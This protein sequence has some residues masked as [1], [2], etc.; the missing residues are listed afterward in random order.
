M[1]WLLSPT[2]HVHFVADKDEPALKRLGAAYKLTSTNLG[3]MRQ[4]LGWREVGQDCR[5]GKGLCKGFTLLE[6][7]VWMRCDGPARG[8]SS[9]R[10]LTTNQSFGPA[11][12]V[13]K[14]AAVGP[15]P[16]PHVVAAVRR[17]VG[18]E[19]SGV[20][21]YVRN[22]HGTALRALVRSV[23]GAALEEGKQV[24]N[25]QQ[26]SYPF[27]A[28]TVKLPRLEDYL[29]AYPSHF[30]V[31]GPTASIQAPQCRVDTL[32][33]QRGHCKAKHDA[34]KLV[35]A[36]HVWTDGEVVKYPGQK[37]PGDA[38]L[39]LT[40]GGKQYLQASAL[41]TGSTAWE[42]RQNARLDPSAHKLQ[43]GIV[44]EAAT[45]EAATAEAATA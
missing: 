38:P 19:R 16:L 27:L 18:E 5:V 33:V 2:F 25:A 42:K 4:L 21:V 26:W 32:L 24:T 6:R 22:K 35:K 20:M 29:R 12:E 34:K 1:A 11:L 37:L 31:D 8:C 39:S 17:L 9:R 7:V 45:A 14:A 13:L 28:R 44:S 15:A 23:L 40:L 3:N 10:Y 41:A 43:A 30:R 36:G